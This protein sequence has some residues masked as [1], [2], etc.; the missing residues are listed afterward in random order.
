MAMLT[1]Q[2]VN[3]LLSERIPAERAWKSTVNIVVLQNKQLAQHGSGSLYRVGNESFLVTAGHVVEQALRHGCAMGLSGSDGRYVA[4]EG[5][6]INSKESVDVSAVRLSDRVVEK[7]IGC[8]FLTMNDV[9]LTTDL[10]QGIFTLFGYPAIWVKDDGEIMDL[11]RFQFT[12]YAF[13]GDPSVLDGFDG[14]FHFLVNGQLIELTEDDGTQVQ[15]KKQDGSPAR[16]PKD[17]GGISGCPVW[18]IADLPAIRCGE[19]GEGPRL[20]G[21]QTGVYSACMKATRWAVVNGLIVNR[22]PEL[23]PVLSMW[24]GK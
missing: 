8:T 18:K 19:P 13:E 1:Q 15:F 24:R 17:L 2:E 11:K 23:K 14:R 4:I 9:S 7:L 21:V 10:S 16:F 12:S 6:S 20:V 22:Y 3:R 5:E